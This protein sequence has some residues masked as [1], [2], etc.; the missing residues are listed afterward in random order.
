MLTWWPSPRGWAVSHP[1]WPAAGGGWPPPAASGRPPRPCSDI[2]IVIIRI[3]II[4]THL[5]SSKHQA[6]QA[7]QVTGNLMTWNITMHNN[8][9]LLGWVSSVCADLCRCHSQWSAPPSPAPP[10]ESGR[11][12]PAAATPALL[13]ILTLNVKEMESVYLY[14]SLCLTTSR[15]E[16]KQLAMATHKPQAT[17][18]LSGHQFR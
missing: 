3:K 11:S 17:S 7:V 16:L 18:H 5:T 2:I 4:V 6:S 10:A 12:A 8:V 13:Q 14:L 1:C 9:I 15:W